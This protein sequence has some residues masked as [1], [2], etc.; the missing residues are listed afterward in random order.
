MAGTGARVITAT[1][2]EQEYK[3]PKNSNKIG[4]AQS[5]VG[6]HKPAVIPVA[7]HAP[8]TNAT[9]KTKANISPPRYL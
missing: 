5:T 3:S 7:T 6:D 1:S 8:P 9:S 2:V 4:T